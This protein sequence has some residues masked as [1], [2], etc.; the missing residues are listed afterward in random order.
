[1][2]NGE[3][4]GKDSAY[5]PGSHHA[6]CSLIRERAKGA[7]ST[8]G[9]KRERQGSDSERVTCEASFHLSLPYGDGHSGSGRAVIG[10]VSVSAF[11]EITTGARL[12][13]K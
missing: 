12:E 7:L 2:G 8:G 9:Q 4:V 1:M 13:R 5:G 10:R 3:K 11:K 6:T